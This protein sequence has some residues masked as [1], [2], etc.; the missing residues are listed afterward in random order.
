[1][2]PDTAEMV[3]FA[4]SPQGT[5]LAVL[6]TAGLHVVDLATGAQ[7]NWGR[8]P[9]FAGSLLGGANTDAMLSWAADGL[10]LATACG[11]D[12]QRLIGVWLLD[13]AHGGNL[14]KYSERLVPGPVYAPNAQPPWDGVRLTGDGRTVVGVLEVPVPHRPATLGPIQELAE[15]SAQTGKLLRILNRMPVRNYVDFEQV[16]WASSSGNSLLVSDTRPYHGRRRA[17]FLL[18][19]AGVL[20]GGHFTPLRGWSL[21]TMAVAF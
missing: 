10:H 16:L 18:N 21:D 20:T 14:I 15:F 1:M 17:F 7:R 13:T 2:L 12:P 3:G 8:P 19:D 9:C 4:L 5:S 11:A 6:D